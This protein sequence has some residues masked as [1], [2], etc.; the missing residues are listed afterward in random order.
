MR[1][2]MSCRSAD[3]ATLEAGDDLLPEKMRREVL[4]YFHG[5]CLGCIA[6]G[7]LHD[8]DRCIAGGSSAGLRYGVRG[9]VPFPPRWPDA[10][11]IGSLLADAGL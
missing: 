11:E 5:F 6:S 10:D 7:Q 3:D 4:A 2:R 8:L 9:G 1:L